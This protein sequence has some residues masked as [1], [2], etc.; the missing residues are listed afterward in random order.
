MQAAIVNIYD[1]ASFAEYDVSSQHAKKQTTLQE[2]LERTAL[3]T[4]LE[5]QPVCQGTKIIKEARTSNVAILPRHQV[6]IITMLHQL[7]ATKLQEYDNFH[8]AHRAGLIHSI[9]KEQLS[10]DSATI[11]NVNFLGLFRKSL[12]AVYETTDIPYQKTS[13]QAL[14]V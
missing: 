9:P 13:K 6:Q 12:L 11:I 1:F 3:K 4:E 8:L 5:E 14:K 10:L 2:S 7:P